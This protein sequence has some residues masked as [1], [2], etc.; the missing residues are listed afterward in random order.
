[1]PFLN[2]N[3]AV[4]LPPGGVYQA[5]FSDVDP[6]TPGVVEQGLLLPW[7]SAPAAGWVYF[8][9]GIDML[10]DSGIVVHNRLPQVD[11]VPD[12]L[13]SCSLDDPNLV[14]L[15]RNGVNLLSRDQYTDIVQRMA[16]S[17]Y[18][19]RIQ[20]QA[21][22]VGQQVP[23]PG[24]KFIGGVPAIPHDVKPQ[25]AFN[26][27]APGG[28]FGGIILWHAGW[29]LWY[30]TL[31]P[32]RTNTFPAADPS[33]HLDVN[34]VNPDGIQAPYSQADDSAVKVAPSASGSAGG[35][36]T[37]GSKLFGGGFQGGSSFG[38]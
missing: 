10:L 1:M 19:F 26:R 14:T 2:N 3:V 24:I 23:I 25:W 12:T 22:R 11:N 37:G 4:G 30:T 7:P 27:I 9:C 17:R 28:N 20:G 13:A 31:V 18:Y 33:A 38:K 15:S 36:S 16:H 34:A 32:P 35:I 6:D 21:L 8:D 5:G 29:S